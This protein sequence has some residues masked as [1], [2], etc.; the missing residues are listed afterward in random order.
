MLGSVT[1]DYYGTQTPLS[2]VANVNTDGRTI[3]VQP[4]EKSCKKSSMQ[5]WSLILDLIQ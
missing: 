2:Q 4:W 3:T 5:L 1:V